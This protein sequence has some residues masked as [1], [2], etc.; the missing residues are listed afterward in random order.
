MFSTYANMAVDAIQSGK[1]TWIDTFIKDESLNKTLTDFVS[2]QTTFVKQ[3]NVSA[4][5][6]ATAMTETF[7]GK[8][9]KK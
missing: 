1:Q 3:A 4:E 2:K 9:F 8:L 5:K 6:V 7:V